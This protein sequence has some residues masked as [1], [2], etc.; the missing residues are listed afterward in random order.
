MMYNGFRFDIYLI[1]DRHTK[2]CLI[3]DKSLQTKVPAAFFIK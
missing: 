3:S 1:G 2:M